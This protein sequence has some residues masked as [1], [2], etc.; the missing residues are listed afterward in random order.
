MVVETKFYETLGVRRRSNLSRSHNACL[1]AMQV[2]YS[3]SDVELKS[4]YRKMAL[5][6][7]P[8]EAPCPDGNWAAAF[9]PGVRT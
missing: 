1:T 6:H 9:V 8:G 5:R 3:A 7:H 4:A 2:S